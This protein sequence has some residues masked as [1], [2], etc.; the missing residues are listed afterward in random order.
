MEPIVDIAKLFAQGRLPKG[1]AVGVLSISGGSGIVYA[2]AAVR[3]GLTLPP[4]SD[5][6]LARAAQDRAGV[7]LAART[8]PTS[9]PASSTTCA[10]SPT[11][12]RSC[13]PIRGLDQ[14]SILLA[15]DLGPDARRAPREAIAAVAAR[16]DKPMHV[17]WSGRHGEV[18]GGA[19]GARPT[20]ACRSSPR[21]CGW[22]ARPPR[23]RASPP[24]S[25]GC[26]RAS[27]PEVRMPQGP[28]PA[29]RRRDAQRGGEQGRAARVRHSDRAGRCF[30]P[31]GADAAA[32]TKGLKAPFAVKIVSRD[33]AHKTEAGGV[34]LGVARDGLADAVRA[35]T[36]QRR[37]GGARRQDRRRARLRDGAGHRGADRR[38]QRR[39]LRA[40]GGAGPRRRAD[41][42]AEGRDLSH[43]ARSTSRPRAR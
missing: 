20:P 43:R 36:R 23:W 16:T 6:T 11:R 19:E 24:T 29:G 3:G 22:R 41:R 13:W 35:V 39:E 1:N 37:Q 32:A 18:A 15:S 5:A 9:P 8:R 33:I 21:R 34:K 40:G 7:R 38:H 28:R 12:S 17:A 30:V 31:S 42:G 27:A 26:C 10:C 14:L 4:F 2:D 25:A